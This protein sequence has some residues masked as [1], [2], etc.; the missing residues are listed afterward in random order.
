M[1]ERYNSA[2]I[3]VAELRRQLATLAQPLYQELLLD[4]SAPTVPAPSMTAVLHATTATAEYGTLLDM[5]TT[6]QQLIQ[7]L[8]P[9]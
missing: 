9:T 1:P 7:S 6:N 2:A 5:S 4:F 3:D 8:F